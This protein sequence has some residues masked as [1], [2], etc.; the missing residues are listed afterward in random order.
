M[1]PHLVVAVDR[2]AVDFRKDLARVVFSNRQLLAEKRI[3]SG[4]AIFEF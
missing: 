3:F 2:L 4:F 1:K